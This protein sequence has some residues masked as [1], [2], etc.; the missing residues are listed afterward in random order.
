MAGVFI[1]PGRPMMQPQKFATSIQSVFRCGRMPILRP[2]DGAERDHRRDGDE[3]GRALHPLGNVGD[4]W[5]DAFGRNAMSNGA[6]GARP[7]GSGF[8]SGHFRAGDR[9]KVTERNVRSLSPRC[10][11]VRVA[12]CKRPI[13]EALR[14]ESRS[15][16]GPPDQ[17]FDSR[18]RRRRRLHALDNSFE[19]IARPRVVVVPKDRDGWPRRLFRRVLAWPAYGKLRRESSG[20]V[21]AQMS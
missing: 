16:A 1:M 7:S 2:K 9:R 5:R 20:R 18:K 14:D 13:M 4:P 17:R 12:L 19:V 8:G 3:I 21:S 10:R 15:S 11:E 6:T